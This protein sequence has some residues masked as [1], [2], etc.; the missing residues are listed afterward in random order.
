MAGL[1]IIGAA[2]CC[3]MCCGSPFTAVYFAPK[4]SD[5]FA[6]RLKKVLPDTASDFIPDKPSEWL[7]SE[8][9]DDYDPVKD[10]EDE[11]QF[12]R[13]ELSAL[14]GEDEAAEL[15]SNMAGENEAENMQALLQLKRGKKYFED[16]RS[17]PCFD[18][19]YDMAAKVDCGQNAVKRFKLSTCPGGKY[20]YEYTCLGGINAK[21][22]DETYDS[23][24]VT[25][26]SLGDNFLEGV[27]IDMRTIYRHPVSC[28]IGGTKGTNDTNMTGSTAGGD[29]PITQFRYDYTVDPENSL[30]NTTKYYYKCLDTIPL[31]KCYNYQTSTSALKPED[32]VTD[33][34]LGLQ[35]HEIKCPGETQVLTHFQLKAGGTAAD[36]TEIP[37]EPVEG[38]T[39]MYRYDYTCC[40]MKAEG[41]SEE[42]EAQGICTMS[43]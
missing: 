41:C 12:L 30:M 26:V 32:L 19:I 27:P 23:P 37:P 4:R 35:S 2:V 24:P 3:S 36:G 1:V 5:E 20:K 22:T 8:Y 39:T 16:E 25:P 17:T 40:N 7:G 6:V 10:E 11:L 14:Y 21:I 31:G 18:N 34:S 15:I 29:S 43:T 28:S 33:G 42:M 13:N 9:E 38:G